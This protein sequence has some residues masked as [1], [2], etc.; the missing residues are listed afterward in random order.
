MAEVSISYKL[1]LVVTLLDTT[2]GRIAE[3][4]QVLFYCNN[5]LLSMNSSSAGVYILM[6]HGRHDMKILAQVKGYEPAEFFVCYDSLDGRYPIVE[7]PLVPIIKPYG[8]TDLCEISGSMEGIEEICAVSLND[9]RAKI[10]AYN[11]KKN[12]LRLF[13]SS[14]LDEGA[15]AV[16]H[17]KNMEFEEFRIIKKA[18]RDLLLYLGEPMQ[19]ECVPE[20]GIARIVRGKVDA[21]GRYLL[22]VRKDGAGTRYLIRFTVNGNKQY[23]LHSF[24]DEEG[25]TL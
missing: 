23:K 8:Y 10:C 9:V 5:E 17:E 14:Q 19:S 21:N 22:R 18:E 12:T 20:E 11:A 4:R 16:V 15:Y 13:S 3:E 7:V 24:D 25:G 2:T 1:D 6:N